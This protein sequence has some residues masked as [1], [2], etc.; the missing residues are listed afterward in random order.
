MIERVLQLP[1]ELER[2]DLAPL[3]MLTP[4]GWTRRSTVV[5]LRGGGAT[6]EG[7]DVTYDAAAQ[8]TFQSGG[9]EALGALVGSRTV[10]E[11][12]E[13]LTQVDLHPGP[14]R[15]QWSRHYRIWALE[16]AALALALTQAEVDLGQLLGREPQ[17]VR[18]AISTGL[19]TPP[20]L[21]TLERFLDAYP[22][23]RFKVD[24][25][26]D[27][28]RATVADL[29]ALGRVDVVDLKGLYR[30]DFAGPPA[31]AEQY[32][33][34]AELLPDCWLEDPELT[35]RTRA[36]LEP[37]MDRVTWDG[38]IH[39][40]ADLDGLERAPRCVNLKPSRSGTIAEYLRVVQACESRGIAM[41]GGGQFELGP[42]R[43]QI[44]ALAAIFHPRGPNDVAP[45]GFNRAELPR[46]LGRSPLAPPRF[47]GA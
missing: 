28:T 20:S 47:A 29:A 24:L 37:H 23:A 13:R 21:A 39:G 38:A 31:D 8:G 22:E 15:D 5:R 46:D 25:G 34:V 35:P 32:R 7:E 26:A 4:S 33:W 43:R 6:G 16:S 18:F 3:E 2:I 36:V 9:L 44:Q 14:A 17:P 40:L 12:S 1:L 42:G 19:G 27:W 30:A 41:Y 45:G 10:G 11:F